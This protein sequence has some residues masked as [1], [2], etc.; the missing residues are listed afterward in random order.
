MHQCRAAGR[1]ILTPRKKRR[2]GIPAMLLLCDA[3]RIYAVC[4]HRDISSCWCVPDPV[5]LLRYRL[6]YAVPFRLRILPGITSL[7][8][9]ISPACFKQTK[10]TR[11][12][13][14]VPAKGEQRKREVRLSYIIHQRPHKGD[15]QQCHLP[16]SSISSY[17]WYQSLIA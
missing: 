10:S 5:P 17:I 3:V 14:Q 11:I 1:D 16:S 9:C 12:N 13:M 4:R 7:K 15:Q 8:C 2:G 6:A